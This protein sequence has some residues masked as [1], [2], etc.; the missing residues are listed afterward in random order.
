[1]INGYKRLDSKSIKKIL[2]YK[3]LRNSTKKTLLWG[4]TILGILSLFMVGLSSFYVAVDNSSQP[5][6]NEN[7]ASSISFKHQEGLDNTSNLNE[8]DKKE[9]ERESEKGKILSDSNEA[10]DY[11]FDTDFH[12]FKLWNDTCDKELMVINANNPLPSDY[13]AETKNCR[14]KEVSVLM[15]DQLENMILDAKKEGILL[16]I[17]SGFR[18]VKLQTRLFDRQVERELS[19]EAISKEE[20]EKRAAKVVAKPYTSEH[21]TGLAVDFNG[22]EDSFYKT[23]EYKWLTG[24][25]HKYGF[26][27]RYQEKW[28]DKTGVIY[29]PWHFRYVGKEHAEKIK[30]SGLCL[31]DYVKTIIKNKTEETHD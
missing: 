12:D 16:W 27:E 20:A 18:S 9:L 7:Y 15:A 11:K 31:E 13:E 2:F 19:K 22:V 26:I 29:E 25:A 30:E 14:G 1:M 6:Q 10:E 4:A 23:K 3:K 24:N 8:L 5:V 17:S 28:K 21:N